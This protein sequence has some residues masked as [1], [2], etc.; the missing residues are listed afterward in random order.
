MKVALCFIISYEHVVNKEQFWIDWIKPNQDIIN[1][2]FHYKN[3]RQILSPWIKTHAIPPKYIQ[4]TTYYQVVPAYISLLTYAFNHDIHNSWFCMLTEACVP[5]I[6]PQMFRE[7]FF[8][9]YQASILNCRPAYWN[10]SLHRRANLQ[11]L[12]KEYWLAND[13]WF[14]LC[15]NHVQ[16]CI[17]FVISKNN[18]YQS[19]NEGGIA[20]ESIFAIIL[21][22][23]KE[24][25]N[26]Q[27]MINENSSV[28][29]WS[30]MSS[31]TSP[32]V[33]KE[34]TDEDVNI[35]CNLLKEHKYTMF[36]RKVH[37]SFPE[38]KLHKIM[39]N[40]DFGH[41]YDQLR[42]NPVKQQNIIY[43]GLLYKYILLLFLFLGLY[44]V[45]SFFTK[46]L[47]QI[48]FFTYNV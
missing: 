46:P 31:P 5:I 39:Y 27:T 7:L 8:N 36:L 4:K 2:Y 42:Y 30:R 26:K 34:G 6:S 47:M 11:L 13:P 18:I 10:I 32:H 15:R 9:H 19:V 1:V 17:L 41:T 25:T 16:K 40:T 44:L 29:D 12:Q 45:T 48:G 28:A 35:I 22:S 3:I 14:T 37:K 24:L 33:F 43:Y 20:N 21:Q 38:E 23:F